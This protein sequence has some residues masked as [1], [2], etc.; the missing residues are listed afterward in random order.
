MPRT[1]GSHSIPA[2]RRVI[3][4]L[5][6]TAATAASMLS[7]GGAATAATPSAGSHLPLA[8]RAS[9]GAVGTPSP[10]SRAARLHRAATRGQV[11]EIQGSTGGEFGS[12]VAISGTTMVVGAPFDNSTAGAAYV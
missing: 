9:T 2:S 3:G 12:S 5:A 1:L 7:A 8:S 4:I 11:G 10:L 6:V